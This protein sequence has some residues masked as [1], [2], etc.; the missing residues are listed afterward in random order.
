MQ[1]ESRGKMTI[2]ELRDYVD[3][4][5]VL[6]PPGRTVTLADGRKI[7]PDAQQ[8]TGPDFQR[9]QNALN[10]IPDAVLRKQVLGLFSTL[11]K[12]DALRIILHPE[13]KI[14]KQNP[15]MIQEVADKATE[16]DRVIDP[17]ARGLS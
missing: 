14:F 15:A 4:R 5:A 13:G 11:S 2:D 6:A 17:T 12:Y 7:R 8:M 3:K 9:A 10:S 1:K 16:L